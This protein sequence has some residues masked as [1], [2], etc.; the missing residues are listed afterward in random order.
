MLSQPF[1]CRPT[2]ASGISARGRT[3]EVKPT[4]GRLLFI[5]RR[6]ISGAWAHVTGVYTESA[7]ESAE[8]IAK[9]I[10]EVYPIATAQQI[11]RVM[12]DIVSEVVKQGEKEE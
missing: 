9:Q 11:R 8:R 6:N 1:R 4:A 7:A 2:S 3:K 12:G 5:L 10:M